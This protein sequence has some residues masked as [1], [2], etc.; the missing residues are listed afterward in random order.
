[1]RL[2]LFLARAAGGSRRKADVWIQEGR[3]RVNSAAP[4]SIGISVEP[5]VD[6]VTL[7]GKPVE[8]PPEHRYL[9]YHKPRGLLVSRRGQGG[10]RT[11]FDVLGARA[12]GLHS[13][14]RLD[15]DS[16]GLMLLTDDG[17]LSESLLHPRT[18]LL[19]RYRAW[20]IP[21]PTPAALRALAAGSR[22]EGEQVAPRR[23]INEGAKQGKGIL[24]IDLAEGKK[25]E[26]RLLARAAGLHIE[27]L[28]RIQFGPI[29]LGT[30]RAG[31]IRP[32]TAG[33]VEALRAGD[34]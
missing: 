3:V 5:T 6:R 2:N 31:G 28:V 21:V 13:V 12:H 18:G 11:I 4:A 8:L 20:V 9:A 26:V 29:H 27:R 30:L 24:L 14:G 7:D 25:R 16:E 15:L 34:L 32:L 10:R 1:V 23:V 19:R 17:T 22:V 33:E